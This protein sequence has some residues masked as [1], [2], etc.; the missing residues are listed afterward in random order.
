M[1][2]ACMPGRATFG[3]DEHPAEFDSNQACYRSIMEAF[4]L[5]RPI[6]GKCSQLDVSLACS[7]NNRA[8]SRIIMRLYSLYSL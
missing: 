8:G 3:L 2:G 7:V 6:Q 4:R 5:S 1:S